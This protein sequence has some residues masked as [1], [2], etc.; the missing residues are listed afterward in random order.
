[1]N[2]LLRET[3]LPPKPTPLYTATTNACKLCTPLGAC[4]A[5]RGVEGAVP[6]LHGSQG[7]A[8]YIRRYLISHYKEPMDI[9]SSAFGEETTIFGGESNLNEGLLHVM[10]SYKPQVVGIA[11]TCL[12]ETI[13]D[14]VR[15]Y[16]HE[17]KKKHESKM[18]GVELIHV[19]TPAYS[20]THVAGFWST[21]RELVDQLA[22]EGPKQEFFGLFP[23][24]VSPAD[25]RYLKEVMKDF[26]IANVLA[27]DY[28]ETLD[29][30]AWDEFVKMPKGGTPVDHIRALGGAQGHIEFTAAMPEHFLP[31]PV[32]TKKFGADSYRMP[33][34]I[35]VSLT[36]AFFEL[37]KELG[38]RSVPD[39]Y[40]EERG[41]LIDSYVDGHKYVAGKKVAIFGEADFVVPMTAF[42]TEIGMKPVLC[43]AGDKYGLLAEALTDYVEDL[44]ENVEIREGCD[45]A[46]IEAE[47]GRLRPDLLIGNSKGYALSRRLNIPL[48]RVGFPIHDRVGGSRVLHLGYEG[49]QRLFDQV[50]NML[51]DHKQNESPVGYSYM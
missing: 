21:I 39:K 14:D 24:M 32:L 6:Y 11:T 25:I 41:R 49:T 45:F 37:L 15:G 10:Q 28:S 40:K 1:M 42:L 30:P 29:G 44:P 47:V 34:P 20:G 16:L 18:K 26:K 19:S 9:A 43:A 3:G 17:F 33:M 12:A 5:F 22:T 35:G 8:T 7:C 38:G 48:L 36:D 23:G 31:S 51:I 50:V 27:P 13:G 4:L 46:D 2:K